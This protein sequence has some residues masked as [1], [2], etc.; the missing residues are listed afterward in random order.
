VYI[1]GVYARKRTS[2][3]EFI[4]AP[5][6]VLPLN[7]A[8]E[9]T[10]SSATSS[11]IAPS[12]TMEW[13]P[14]WLRSLFGSSM[15]SF[16]ST[17]TAA[18]SIVSHHGPVDIVETGSGWLIETCVKGEA[19]RARR[20]ALHRIEKFLAQQD[21]VGFH[22]QPI[23]PLMQLAEAPGR[24]RIRL[25]L[26]DGD[27]GDLPVTRNGKVRVRQIFPEALAVLRVPGRP[28]SLALRHAE[29]AIRHAVATTHWEAAGPVMLRLHALPAVLPFLGRFEV[30]VPVVQRVQFT[31]FK[32][33]S[34]QE[35][36]T[37]ASPPTR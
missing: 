29:V 3:I 21:R 28:T 5:L 19:E 37:P 17:E 22:L 26:R 12:L 8:V 33:P 36:A 2:P 30:A 27:V 6:H 24:W 10:V 31:A 9:L 25:F 34:P 35:A 32:D 7:E 23:K 15:S 4:C 11:A 18:E 20:S 1:C 14:S 13:L 16:R